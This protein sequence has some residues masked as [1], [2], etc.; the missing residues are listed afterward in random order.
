VQVKNR[1]SIYVLKAGQPV[2]ELT[3]GDLA[4]V[5]YSALDKC[6][7]LSPGTILYHLDSNGNRDAYVNPTTGMAY[8]KEGQKILVWPVK[9]SRTKTGA[10]IAREKIKTWRIASINADTDQEY[11]T[12]AYDGNEFN[13]SLNPVLN[14]HGLPVYYQRSGQVYKKG[15]P[16]YDIDGDFVRY[17]YDDLLPAYNNAAYRINDKTGME[18]IGKEED[19]TDDKKLYHR[20]G[21]AWVMENTWISGE[22]FP[23][24]PFKADMT[25]G[26]ADMLK[27]V[28]PGTYILEEVKAPSGYTKG[29]PEGVTVIETREVQKTGMEDEKIKVEIVKTDAPD[30]YRIDVL[31]DY[32]ENLKVTEPKGA[33]SYSQVSGA[34]LALYKAKR[35]YTTESQT[36][37]KGYYFVKAESKPAEWMI[38]NTADNAPV[39]IVADWITDG[40]PKYF[41]GI[42]AGDYILEEIDTVVGYVRSSM[43]LTVKATG[44]VQTVNLKNDHTKL[45]VYKYYEDSAGKKVQLPN[46]H[47]A[48]LALYEAITDK[49]GNIFMDG[50]KPVY[51]KERRAAKWTTDDLTEYTEKTEKSTGFIN[52]IKNLLGLAENQSSFITDFEA[53]RPGRKE[54]ASQPSP[55]TRKTGSGRPSEAR[56]SIPEKERVPSRLGPP[57]PERQSGSP[58]T[59]MLKMVPLIQ[60]ESFL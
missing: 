51:D 12:G 27:R 15:A 29:F 23:N 14:S 16:V 54:K 8:A 44:E 31:S 53:G 21:E 40:T 9:I 36:N 24:D 11:V 3:G 48:D 33:Y 7:N 28:I 13:K 35:V 22:K 45:E 55:G 41:E 43:E 5:K 38:E 32:Q 6:F 10:V 4:A 25:I 47:T 19:L 42:P 20:Q 56:V 57:I 60:M 26:Q 1:E 49:D 39:R 34:H 30:Q 59:V 2:Y 58:Y 46:S 50:V 37:P 18:N 17:K 52:R